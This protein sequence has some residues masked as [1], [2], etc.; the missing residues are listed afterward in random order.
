MVKPRD[1][2]KKFTKA[3]YYQHPEEYKGRFAEYLDLVTW[4]VN[5]IYWEAKYPVVL[6][7]KDLKAAMQAG[8]NKL[9]GVTDISADY[10]G[11]VDFTSIFTSIEE[12]FLLYNP[13]E[14]TFKMK[15]DD[16]LDEND[17]LFTSVDHLPAEMPREASNHF[18]SKLMPF[19]EAVVKSD[20]SKP[21]AEQSDLPPEIHGAV[22]TAHGEL[23]P[24]FAYI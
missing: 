17:I 7:K 6:A 9:I 4:L 21:F 8:K 1:P 12:P 14:N 5:G 2:S 20:F 15:I 22:I 16:N 18:G 19:V 23:T 3:H 13:M 24:D 10:E 11:S